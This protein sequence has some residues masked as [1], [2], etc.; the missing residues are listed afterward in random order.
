MPQTRLLAAGFAAL[1]LFGGAVAAVA[2][3]PLGVDQAVQARQTAMKEDGRAL[4]HADKLT[5]DQAVQA[6]TTVAANYEKLPGL[7]PKGSVTD[8]SV[9]LPVIWDRFDEFSAIFKKGE[10]AAASGIAAAKAGDAADYLGAIK[11]I[12]GTCDDCHRTFRAKR[13]G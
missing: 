6:L 5:G 1:F 3:S 13:D 9:A 4:R 8:K 7:F 12:G 10:D 11:I 2:D